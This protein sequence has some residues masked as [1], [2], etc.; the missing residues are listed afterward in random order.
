MLKIF[1]QRE[2]IKISIVGQKFKRDLRPKLAALIDGGIHLLD[3][4]ICG[5]I[6]FFHVFF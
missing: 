1:K 5:G 2:K 3:F 6:V 4:V